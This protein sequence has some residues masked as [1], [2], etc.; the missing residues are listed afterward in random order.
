VH[1]TTRAP[2]GG[3]VIGPH[4]VGARRHQL[5]DGPGRVRGLAPALGD[6]AVGPQQAVHGGFRAQVGALVEQRGPDL[7]G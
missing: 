7:G 2:Q 6:L 4:L 5:G 1:T 3:G